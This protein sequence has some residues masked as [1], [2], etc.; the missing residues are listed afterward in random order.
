ML[1]V[2]AILIEVRELLEGLFNVSRTQIEV[3]VFIEDSKEHSVPW[4]WPFLIGVSTLSLRDLVKY[5]NVGDVRVLALLVS[6][7]R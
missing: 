1:E 3:A 5:G 7:V 6:V 2:Q 4:L